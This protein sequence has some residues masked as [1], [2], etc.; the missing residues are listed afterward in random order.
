MRYQAADWQGYVQQ[1]VNLMGHGYQDYCLVKL[2]MKKQA[3]WGTIDQRIAGKYCADL[4]KDKRYRRQLKGLANYAYLR[5]EDAAVIL[6]TNG[7]PLPT[8]DRFV[9]LHDKPLQVRVGE[10]TVLK[11]VPASHKGRKVTVYLA[12]DKYR[13]I[14]AGLLD[15]V[16]HRQLDVLHG[17]FS[18]LDGLPPYAGIVR[19]KAELVTAIVLEGKRH[20][21]KLCRK[22]FPFRTKRRNKPVFAEDQCGQAQASAG[23]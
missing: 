21:L 22:D 4:G 15:N 19:Q 3:E 12:K 20:G 17:A 6:R 1:I 16:R 18:R 2:P 11:V 7:E 13:E 5:W 9:S 10:S 8:T 14:K 23:T